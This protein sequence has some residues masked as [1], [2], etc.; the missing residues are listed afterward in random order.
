MDLSLAIALFPSVVLLTVLYRY[1][2]Y[3][4]EEHKHLLWAFLY[5]V[6]TIPLA[7]LLEVA[8]SAWQDNAFVYAFGIVGPIEEGLKFLFLILFLYR[9]KF[10]DEPYDGIIYAGYV[11]LGFA[12][13]ENIFYVY[14]YGIATGILRI[15]TA[16]PAHAVFGVVMGYFVGSAKFGEKKKEIPKLL[17]G[18]L[19][20]PVFLHGLYDY[21]LF[22]KIHQGLI[23]F[24]FLL[25]IAGFFIGWRALKLHAERSPHKPAEEIT[26]S[27]PGNREET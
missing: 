19:L 7:L 1:D 22:Q 6:A 21:F 11:S 26:S 4:K 12:T 2:K 27:L 24:S 13:V 23:V 10:L 17:L 16:V 5:G 8:M 9:K 15:F 14:S 20:L 3:E 25:V 18:G